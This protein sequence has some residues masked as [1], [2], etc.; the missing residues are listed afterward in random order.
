MPLDKT[1]I[2]I[3]YDSTGAPPLRVPSPEGKLEPAVYV[4]EQIAD[5]LTKRGHTVTLLPAERRIRALSLQLEKDQSDVIFNICESFGGNNHHEQNVA[6]LLEL[7]GKPFTGSSSLGLAL[8]QD[9]GLS[10]KFFSYHNLPYPKFS[11]MEAGAALWADDLQFPLF[12]KPLNQDAS[13]GIDA[14]AVVY[15]VK[16]LLARMSYIH[17]EIKSSVL[18]E[19]Y[20][21][22]RE[23]YVGVLGNEN[24]KALPVIEWDFSKLS[25]TLPRIATAEAKWDEDSD[26]FKAPEIFP[27]DIPQAVLASVQKVAVTAFK[28]LHLRGYGRVDFRLRRAPSDRAHTR[29]SPFFSDGW[30]FFIIEVNPN[31]YLDRKAE[32]ASASR[33]HGL[34]FPALLEYIIEQA[35]VAHAR[36]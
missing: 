17:T 6:A 21:D 20:I 27:T 9:K 30:E 5:A 13:V 8:A 16:E 32:V 19:E 4:H 15:S 25:P 34:S 18:I 36:R 10:K 11:I 33:K 31:P 3:L 35:L 28:A 26:A 14:N 23:L 24:P 22:G 1:K 2:T 29:S 7:I 12:V